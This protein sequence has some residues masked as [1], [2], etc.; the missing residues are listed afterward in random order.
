MTQ[1]FDRDRFIVAIKAIV[2]LNAS[3][4]DEALVLDSNDIDHIAEEIADYITIE[5]N[6]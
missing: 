4:E 3:N 5:L 2:N 1:L 6:K